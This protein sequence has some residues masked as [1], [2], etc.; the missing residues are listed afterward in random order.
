VESEEVAAAA[1]RWLARPNYRLTVV[2]QTR[3]AAGPDGADRS[4]LPPMGPESELVLPPVWEGHLSNGIR[5]IHAQ[6]DGTPTVDMVMA[7]DAGG[8]ADQGLKP[9][10]QGFAV[11]LMDDGTGTMTGQ[12]FT[13]AQEMLGARLYAYS[14]SDTTSFSVSALTRSLDDTIELWSQ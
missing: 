2:P 5:V 14:S 10:L 7:F 6:R 11:G 13:L 3:Y 8:A 12:E 1:N 4:Q 9:G